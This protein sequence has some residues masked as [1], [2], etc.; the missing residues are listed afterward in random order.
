MKEAWSLPLGPY[1]FLISKWT[2]EEMHSGMRKSTWRI[3]S[4]QEAHISTATSP[5][6]VEYS[7]FHE[8]FQCGIY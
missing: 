5:A 2:C 8:N 3:C 4:T 7:D 6:G 1:W